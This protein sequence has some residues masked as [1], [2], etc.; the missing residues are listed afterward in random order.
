MFK[1]LSKNQKSTLIVF[2][3]LI[4]FGIALGIATRLSYSRLSL[5]EEAYNDAKL[6][7]TPQYANETDENIMGYSVEGAKYELENICDYIFE[8]R[9]L[10]VEHCF[11]TTKYNVEVLKTVKGDIDESGKNIVIYHGSF[12]CENSDNSMVFYNI[13]YSIPL[14]PGK[15][16]LVFVN[17]MN[18][19][20]VYQDTLESNEYYLE[21][22][23][24]HPVSYAL[25]EIQS[26]YIDIERDKAFSSL[27]DKSYI[28]FSQEALDHINQFT[29]EMIE[30]YDSK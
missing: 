23:V 14:K 21:V 26:T 5:N 8:I 2:I 30:Y 20:D 27:E 29:T 1:N 13:D 9:C 28:C 10:D 19:T 11:E 15:S 3:I 17:K 12:F 4:V 16:Y 6:S 7:F 18:Y 22:F 24:C 25:D